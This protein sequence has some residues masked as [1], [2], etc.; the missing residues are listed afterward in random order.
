MN[1]FKIWMAFVAAISTM[2]VAAGAIT[3]AQAA[4]MRETASISTPSGPPSTR[5]AS[6]PAPL[7]AKTSRYVTLDGKGTAKL[8]SS[9]G[10]V[11]TTSEMSQVK[12]SIATY[13]SLAVKSGARTGQ[14]PVT[15]ESSVMKTNRTRQPTCARRLS[16]SFHWWGSTVRINGC[17]AAW[18][19]AAAATITGILTLT[20]VI[21]AG[22]N[23][24]NDVAA[25]LAAVAA[26][27]GAGMYLHWLTCQQLG[28][29]GVTYN[30]RFGIVNYPGCWSA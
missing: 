2:L 13:N 10:R 12:N 18:L 23:I 5:A 11:L 30:R 4:P 29:K 19:A 25:I 20:A 3:P 26:T 7:I 24:A 22:L 27:A 8:S 17:L 9:A 15:H 6:L 28:Y 14:I 16:W 1:R 21:Q